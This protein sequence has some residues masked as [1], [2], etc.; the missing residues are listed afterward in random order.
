MLLRPGRCELQ[1]GRGMELVSRL[2]RNSGLPIFQLWRH[3]LRP[4]QPTGNAELGANG[5]GVLR[6]L[7]PLAAMLHFILH[8]FAVV[9]RNPSEISGIS[10]NMTQHE[11]FGNSKAYVD[12]TGGILGLENWLGNLD[13]NQD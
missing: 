9:T 8:G 13:S 7:Q 3:A 1:S 10:S 11:I 4:Q 2:S 6:L 5:F 12:Q